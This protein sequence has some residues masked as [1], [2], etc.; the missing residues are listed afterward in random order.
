MDNV[1]AVVVGAG[2]VGL[3]VARA[4]ARTGLEVVIL[5][6]ENA[7]GTGVSARNSEVIHAGLYYPTHSLKAAL[8]VQGRQQLYAF[9]EQHHVPHRRCGKLLVATSDAERD[10]LNDIAKQALRNGVSDVQR[11]SAAQARAMEPELAC[12]EALWSPST[13]I[14]D[15]HA[16]MTALLADAQAHGAQLALCT[17][18]TAAR[19]TPQG[20]ILSTHES[21]SPSDLFELQT[22][23]WINCAGLHAVGLARS[24]EGM[25]AALLPQAH[26]A[27]GH[28]FALSG[29]SPFEHLVYPMPND[30]GLGI[31]LTLDL[32]GQARFGPDTEWL[33]SPH[34]GV[35]PSSFDYAVSDDRQA[36]FYQD[37]RRYWPGLPDGG[38]MPAYSGIRPKI[39]PAGTSPDFLLLGPAQHGLPGCVHLLG[40]ESPGL[41]SCLALADEV[42]RMLKPLAA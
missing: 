25:P 12:V 35:D 29:R 36:S 13:G 5:E 31:H 26:Y 42:V 2:V 10:K 27:K 32:G 18:V 16:L 3:A 6:S 38:L 1:D 20:W 17:R 7:F 41:T 14:V 39:G 30:G 37:I 4:L 19:P 28:Y 24:T 11:L 9:C 40:I 33:P 23:Q 8:C 15:S 21:T 22:R 34:G